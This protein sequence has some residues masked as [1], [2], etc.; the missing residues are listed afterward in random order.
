MALGA[1]QSVDPEHRRQPAHDLDAARIRVAPL[2]AGSL[3]PGIQQPVQGTGPDGPV[4]HQQVGGG[5]RAAPILADGADEAHGDTGDGLDARRQQ[6]IVIGTC[7]RQGHRVFGEQALGQGALL[8]FFD[9]HQ[10][11]PGPVH[12]AHR[13]V[14]GLG[15]P[16][17][18]RRSGVARHHAGLVPR[19]LHRR[20]STAAKRQQRR[21]G[22]NR[23]S[24]GQCRVPLRGHC[25][26]SAES[27][28]A[29]DEPSGG[30]SPGSDVDERLRS[31]SHTSTFGRA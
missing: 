28:V 30:S 10:P 1:G 12:P 4:R 24:S 21:E 20:E 8:F 23:I 18:A 6:C 5:E 22:R 26:S 9:R 7:Q 31:A 3:G 13:H 15:R 16:A 2:V 11:H 17:C 19:V 27:S 25:S 14:A 29:S